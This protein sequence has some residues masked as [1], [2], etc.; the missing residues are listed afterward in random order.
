MCPER[1]EECP[2]R[3]CEEGDEAGDAPENTQKRLFSG[4]VKEGERRTNW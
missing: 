3:R 2:V 1:L 4:R